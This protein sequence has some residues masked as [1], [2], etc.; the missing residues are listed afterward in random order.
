M[1]GNGPLK[2]S[3][4]PTGVI[5]AGEDPVALDLIAATL[6]GF[7]WKRLNMLA[8]MAT[9]AMLQEI[10]VASNVAELR[11]VATLRGREPHLPPAGWVESRG[12]LKAAGPMDRRP[13][14]SSGD[15]HYGL[16]S[17]H[18]GLTPTTYATSRYSL[19]GRSNRFDSDPMTRPPVCR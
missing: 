2:G 17:Q 11:D 4:R 3:P 9:E 7:D 13:V 19:H 18:V 6:I 8:G 10:D 5:L 15:R 1:E 14:R 16:G 12:G